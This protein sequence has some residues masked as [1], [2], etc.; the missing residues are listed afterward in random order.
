M[1]KK[2]SPGAWGDLPDTAAVRAICRHLR[3]RHGGRHGKTSLTPPI[4][5]H[6]FFSGA[7]LVINP[8]FFQLPLTSFPLFPKAE[9]SKPVPV[10]HRPRPRQGIHSGIISSPSFSSLAIHPHSWI[11]SKQISDIIAVSQNFLFLKPAFQ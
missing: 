6:F 5:C 11:N 4:Q 2:V 1:A 7:S 9:R 10:P 8:I 3:G